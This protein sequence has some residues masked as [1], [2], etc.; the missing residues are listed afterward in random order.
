METRAMPVSSASRWRQGELDIDGLHKYKDKVVTANVKGVEYLFKKGGITL[1]SGR[2]KLAGPARSPW[3]NKTARR[4]R[5]RRSPRSSR[6]GRS[7]EAFPASSSMVSR[8]SIPTTRFPQEHSGSMIVLGAGA[9]GV[10]FA[11]IYATFGA[12]VTIVE[13]LP[14]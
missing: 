2:G 9:V 10:E 5:S 13:L 11:S 14:G 12:K 6:R 3:R 1:V 7:S 8:S 4:R